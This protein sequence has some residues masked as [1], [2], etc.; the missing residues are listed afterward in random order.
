MSS[1]RMVKPNPKTPKREVK[2][3][4]VM[5]TSNASPSQKNNVDIIALIRTLHEDLS[6]RIKDESTNNY[7]VSRFMFKVNNTLS[8]TRVSLSKDPKKLQDLE[9]HILKTETDK[10]KTTRAE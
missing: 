1:I 9:V 6:L 4:E 3:E 7:Y 2:T 10:V 8:I 5:T